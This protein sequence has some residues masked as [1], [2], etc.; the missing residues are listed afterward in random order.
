MPDNRILIG[1]GQ[2][3]NPWSPLVT[4]TVWAGFL[5][6]YLPTA[7]RWKLCWV[8]VGAKGATIYSELQGR[9]CMTLSLQETQICGRGSHSVELFIQSSS[10]SLFVH[11]TNRD[12]LQGFVDDAGAATRRRFGR[13]G[14]IRRDVDDPMHDMF[15]ARAHLEGL[16]HRRRYRIQLYRLPAER[17]SEPSKKRRQVDPRRLLTPRS[18]RPTRRRSSTHTWTPRWSGCWRRSI[19]S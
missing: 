10:Q 11:S 6:V 2:D 19:P 8:F 17:H 13:Q 1:F 5:S 16:Y 3:L 4:D 14:P 12:E 15:P 7:D 18:A 9:P